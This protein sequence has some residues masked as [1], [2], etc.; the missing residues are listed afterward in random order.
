MGDHFTQ[1]VWN[2]LWPQTP[3]PGQMSPLQRLGYATAGP[4]GLQK[5]MQDYYAQM[6]QSAQ[7]AAQN[8]EQFAMRT[9]LA[10]GGEGGGEGGVPETGFSHQDVVG[11][12]DNLTPEEGYV[13][14]GSTLEN[15]FGMQD[16]G[17]LETHGPSYGT[18]QAAWPDG[19]TE[20]RSYWSADPAATQY[21]TPEGKPV[22]IRAPKSAVEFK[23]ESTGDI[24]A[25]KKVPIKHLE[26][27]TK[28]G[29]KPLSD[30]GSGGDQ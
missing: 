12:H 24:Y 6:Q 20:R 2:K 15:A 23:R 29:W 21:F 18:D 25:R 26:I 19:R 9:A 28:D 27:L 4:Q 13:Y 16:S 22:V 5:A 8:P 1:Q 10:F 30:M 17:G 11:P 14:H 7:Q 3:A